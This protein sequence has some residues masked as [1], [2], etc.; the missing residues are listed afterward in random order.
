MLFH[1]YGKSICDDKTGL[2]SEI[3]PFDQCFVVEGYRV[4]K[5]YVSNPYYLKHMSEDEW[6]SE[7]KNHR[8]EN[9]YICRNFKEKFFVINIKNI[10][11]LLSL[12]KE[13]NVHIGVSYGSHYIYKNKI[14][15][16]LHYDYCME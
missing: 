6:Y 13:S 4:D 3:K 8:T 9:G 16:E 15:P 1:I 10:K 14:L 5:R 2:F 11:D 7:G 12:Q